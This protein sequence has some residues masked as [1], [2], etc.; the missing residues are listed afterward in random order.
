MLLIDGREVSNK[1]KT[2]LKNIIEKDHLTPGLG[3][4]L[5]GE[6]ED[7]KVYVNMKKKV[8]LV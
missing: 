1:I 3:I 7:S 5:V 6:R 8:K 4:I 2:E